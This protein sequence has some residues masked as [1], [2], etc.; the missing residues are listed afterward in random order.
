[1]PIKLIGTVASNNQAGRGSYWIS[2]SIQSTSPLNIGGLKFSQDMSTLYAGLIFDPSSIVTGL[3]SINASNYLTNW[4]TAYQYYDAQVNFITDLDTDSS[5]NIYVC[6][7]AGSSRDAFVAKYNSSGTSQWH[8]KLSAGTGND[9]LNSIVYGDGNIYSCG[10]TDTPISGRSYVV[11]YSDS[12]TLNWQKIISDSASTL[13]FEMY[14]I[15]YSSTA[16]NKIAIGGGGYLNSAATRTP[17]IGTMSTTGTVAWFKRGTGNNGQITGVSFDTTGNIYISGQAFIGSWKSFVAKFDNSGTML[18]QRSI[19]CSQ[20]STIG[21]NS[22][23]DKD[24]NIYLIT[25]TG[26][27]GILIAK[28]NSSGTIQWQRKLTSGITAGSTFTIV[29]DGKDAI[30]VGFIENNGGANFA[31]LTKFK[32]TGSGTGTYSLSSRSYTYSVS[33]FTESDHGDTWTSE[34]VTTSN[35]TSTGSSPSVTTKADTLSF[36]YVK[37]P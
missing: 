31:M 10:Y 35:A 27:D 9:V 3:I 32:D 24:G 17:L 16:T 14:G 30:S 37:V 22:C 28:W 1:M 36:N 19:S 13:F 26:S 5:N 33:S 2:R 15:A 7:E 8:R 6:A 12:G 25:Y 21:G 34:T 29:H 23:I 18:W 11:S 20:N 4:Q